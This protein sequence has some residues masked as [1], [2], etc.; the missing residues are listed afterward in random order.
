MILVHHSPTLMCC[1]NHHSLQTKEAARPAS[2]HLRF[3][4]GCS[5][6]VIHD[7]EKHFCSGRLTNKGKRKQLMYQCYLRVRVSSLNWI[8]QSTK[9]T[10]NAFESKNMTVTS[11]NRT[12]SY[13]GNLSWLQPYGY[14][15]WGL[16]KTK[17]DNHDYTAQT[18]IK[19]LK[20]CL[21]PCR[22]RL[23]WSPGPDGVNWSSP[24]SLCLLHHW[25]WGLSSLQLW[26]W[27]QHWPA[28]EDFCA[29]VVLQG[30][31]HHRHSTENLTLWNSFALHFVLFW[32]KGKSVWSVKVT[33]CC[34]LVEFQ[35]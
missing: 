12:S 13:V 7:Q 33:F 17:T 3:T 32:G 1:M 26:T 30:F 19:G 23:K 20:H 9:S 24:P 31:C 27:C 2:V 34:H 21:C 29:R 15:G 28:H 18:L 22:A 25:L 8:F 5:P 35:S 6:Q 14:Y 10:K 4:G 11:S 16:M